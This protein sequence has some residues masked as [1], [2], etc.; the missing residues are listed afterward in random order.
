MPPSFAEARGSVVEQVLQQP[1]R[2]VEEGR[3]VPHEVE[4]A[5]A[6]AVKPAP[7]SS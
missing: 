7:S 2:I 1:A 5:H 4:L 3:P 6:R